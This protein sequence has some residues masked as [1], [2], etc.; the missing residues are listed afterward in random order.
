MQRIQISAPYS[1]EYTGHA[2]DGWVARAVHLLGL[3]SPVALNILH[4]ALPAV[5]N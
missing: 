3:G 5:R 2:R 4:V 1:P